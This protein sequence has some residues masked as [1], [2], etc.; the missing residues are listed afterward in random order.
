MQQMRLQALQQQLGLTDEDFAA[1]TPKIQKVMQLQQDANPRGGRGGRGG[2]GPGGPGGLGGPG[3]GGFNGPPN[4]GQPQSDVQ[5]A[6]AEVQ[7]ALDDPNSTPDLIKGKLDAYRAAVA[8]AKD[9]Y[10]AAQA[11]LKQL[12]TQ[13]Q[14]AVMVMAGY[15]N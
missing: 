9:D 8:K 3:G 2:G 13:R 10:A 5:K 11:D 6:R 15:L 4:N 14:E 1:L 7:A 12:L